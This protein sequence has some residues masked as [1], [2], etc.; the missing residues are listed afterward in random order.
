MPLLLLVPL[1]LVVVVALWLVLLPF[2]LWARYRNGGARRRAVGWGVRANAALLA[3]SIPLLLLS[4]L[5]GEPL[6][7]RRAA[8][9][10]GRVLAGLLVGGLGLALTRF[11]H[12]A[13]GFHY[14]PHR[15]IALLLT[16]V[17]ALRILGGLWLSGAR[18]GR[19]RWRQAGRRG[20]RHGI[21]RGPLAAGRRLVRHRR[22]AARLQRRLFLGAAR[23]PA[24]A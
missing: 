13:S 18:H 7:G 6:G 19:T 14:T 4:G 24:T 17:V 16:A 5:A 20:R 23:A 22:T 12:D 11:E 1:L 9:R 21:G 3:L 10:C 8:R 15:A 2:G